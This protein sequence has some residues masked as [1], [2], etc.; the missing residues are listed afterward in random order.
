MKIEQATRTHI[1]TEAVRPIL[2]E[3]TPKERPEPRQHWISDATMFIIDSRHLMQ[4]KIRH[5]GK[6]LKKLIAEPLGAILGVQRD[7]EQGWI[8]AKFSDEEAD[9][10]STVFQYVGAVRDERE[11]AEASLKQIVLVV[12]ASIQH[13]RANYTSEQSARVAK[14]SEHGIGSKLHR[15]I[16]PLKKVKKGAKLLFHDENWNST[17]DKQQESLAIKR[18]LALRGRGR[19]AAYEYLANE[20]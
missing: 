9:E 10:I 8:S 11:A 2:V 20:V 19:L 5:T 18:R 15:S 7:L 1:I 14:T 12:E 6:I 17:S 3:V 13:D 16:R 4:R